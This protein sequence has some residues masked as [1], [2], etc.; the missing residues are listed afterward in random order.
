M[1]DLTLRRSQEHNVSQLDRSLAQWENGPVAIP[2]LVGRNTYRRSEGGEEV[3]W[4]DLSVAERRAISDE[5]FRR[6]EIQ[7]FWPEN[8]FD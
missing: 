6:G 1:E 3:V 5:E 4:L 7:E 2:T 8:F